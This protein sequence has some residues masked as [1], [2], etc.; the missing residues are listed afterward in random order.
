[1]KL[2]V[3]DIPCDITYMVYTNMVYHSCVWYITY[4]CGISHIRT[5]QM[6]KFIVGVVNCEE[7]L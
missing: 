2:F 4:L 1:M 5:F 6:F 7:L 3:C